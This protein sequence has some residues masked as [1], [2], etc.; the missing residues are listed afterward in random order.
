MATLT[1]WERRRRERATSVIMMTQRQGPVGLSNSALA[2]PC[3]GVL[4]DTTRRIQIT[5]FVDELIEYRRRKRRKPLT[6]CGTDARRQ[7]VD[8]VQVPWRIRK[9][10]AGFPAEQTPT[11]SSYC[12]GFGGARL[13]HAGIWPARCSG[14]SGELTALWVVQVYKVSRLR[15]CRPDLTM[16]GVSRE[17]GACATP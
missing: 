15:W 4:I 16:K 6:I 5:A 10:R 12:A 9:G 1:T 14:H 11:Q 7:S 17:C 8:S 13:I 3:K 2:D